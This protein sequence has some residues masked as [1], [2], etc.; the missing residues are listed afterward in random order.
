MARYTHNLTV[1]LPREQVQDELADALRACD[2]EVLHQDKDYLVAREV[3]GRSALAQLVTVEILI[4]DVPVE[5][6]VTRVNVVF[7]NE[8]LPLSRNNHCSQIYRQV[9]Q[10]LTE[11]R[12]WELIGSVSGI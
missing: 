10:A 1:A 4:N 12:N 9:R 7:K 6:E 11:E 2:L 5:P 3:P 8:E